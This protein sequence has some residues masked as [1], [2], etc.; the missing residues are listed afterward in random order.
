MSTKD[1]PLGEYN[2]I[3]VSPPSV[4]YGALLFFSVAHFG[5]DLLPNAPLATLWVSAQERG[6]QDR[7]LAAGARDG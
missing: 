4:V 6:K 5:P 7:E 2:S 3:S 1:L